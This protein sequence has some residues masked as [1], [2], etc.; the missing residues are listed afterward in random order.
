[1][2]RI[3]FR[4]RIACE[5]HE[6]KVFPE[7]SPRLKEFLFDRRDSIHLGPGNWCPF[8]TQSTWWWPEAYPLLY[9]PSSCSFRMC[10]IW[11]GFVAQKCLWQTGQGII[12]H[13]PEVKQNRNQ[14]NL[15]RDFEDE[16][17]GYLSNEKIRKTLDALVFDSNNMN[18]NLLS[19]Y[20][21]LVEGGFFP[22]TELDLVAT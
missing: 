10:D 7:L 6:S 11:R 21:A 15:F 22:N 3:R 1:M 18:H 8:N 14:H 5:S 19:C 16:I 9:I 13:A 2:F 20:E 12:F 4:W 17:D